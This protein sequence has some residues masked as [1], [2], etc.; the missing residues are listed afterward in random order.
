MAEN[1]NAPTN[2]DKGKIVGEWFKKNMIRA[3]HSF[4]SSITVVMILI[5]IVISKNV[6]S[7]H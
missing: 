6:D 2:V 5:P 4:S 1:I 3:V 7:F